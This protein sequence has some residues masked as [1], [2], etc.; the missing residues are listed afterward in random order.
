MA[1]KANKKGIINDVK[2]TLEH[3]IDFEL[4]RDYVKELQKIVDDCGFK[5]NLIQHNN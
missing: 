4:E 2:S 5:V 3:E 1:D